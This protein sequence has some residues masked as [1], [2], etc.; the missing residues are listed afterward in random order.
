MRW[1]K[2]FLGAALA[3]LAA[4]WGCSHAPTAPSN[5]GSEEPL[6]LRRASRANHGAEGASPVNLVVEQVISSSTGGSLSLLD[7]SLQIPPGAVPNDT[8]FSIT[9][10]DDQVFYNEFGTHGLVFNVPVTVTM[11]YRDA[12]L[13]GIDESTITVAWHNGDSGQWEAIAC[14][15]DQVNKTVT[16]Q[17]NHFSAYGL[18]SDVR[19]GGR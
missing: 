2:V 4:V 9:I 7:V 14:V 15:L 11:S 10:P 8:L 3:G 16:G 6:V 13:T 12:D 5:S 17:L 1:S 19:G 18:I